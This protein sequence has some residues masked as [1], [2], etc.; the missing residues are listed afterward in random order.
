[1]ETGVTSWRVIA[2][3]MSG[4]AGKEAG[5]VATSFAEFQEQ[6][7]DDAESKS[8]SAL[9]NEA[10]D[11]LVDAASQRFVRELANNSKVRN[12]EYKLVMVVG[13]F[14]ANES[15]EGS[16][17]MRRALRSL[18]ERLRKNERLRADFVFIGMDRDAAQKV[19]NNTSGEPADFLDPYGE[20]EDNA[21]V[22]RY[23]PDSVV[24]LKGEMFQSPD[25]EAFKSKLDLFV[26]V[27]HPRT[28]ARYADFN[29]AQIY[30]YHPKLGWIT[31]QKDQELMAACEE[32]EEKEDE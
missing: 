6:K 24:V 17:G 1:L 31:E 8:R 13:D 19:I 11:E 30:R 21:N 27:V 28:G 20:G 10:L 23:H 3:L 12:S 4:I 32:K 26:D 16:D 9:P 2:A 29:L 14:K 18:V 7:K 5:S 25:Y 15:S 22:V